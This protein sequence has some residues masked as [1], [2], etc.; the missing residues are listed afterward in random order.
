MCCVAVTCNFFCNFTAEHSLHVQHSRHCML[1]EGG[2]I[3]GSSSRIEQ[4]QQWGRG[5]RRRRRRQSQR[6]WKSAQRRS[7]AKLV[8]IYL[9]FFKTSF[10]FILT[11]Y[12]LQVCNQVSHALYLFAHVQDM[13]VAPCSTP[14]S[15]SVIFCLIV[16]LCVCMLYLNKGTTTRHLEKERVGWSST[17]VEL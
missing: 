14:L 2:V 7:S 4:R 15:Q 3:R 17:S 1:H 5:H 11:K 10:H 6:I 9:E 16:G 13:A 12:V 8:I